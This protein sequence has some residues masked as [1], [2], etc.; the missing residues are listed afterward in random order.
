MP[1]P[2]ALFC[3]IGGVFLTDAWGV[4]AR[5]KAAEAFQL[6]APV[7]E[8]AHAAL[9][10]PLETGRITLDEY[11]DRAV[12]NSPRS[13]TK[14]AFK[15]FMRAQSQPFPEALGILRCLAQ[16]KKYFLACLNN[17]SRELNLHRIR[18][19][20]LREYFSVFLSSCYLGLRKPDEAI[21]RV[22]L[23]I[24]QRAPQESLFI[25]DRE[26]NVEGARRAGM[27][28]IHYQNPAA[29]RRELADYGVII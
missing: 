21:Y 18:S 12:F 7:F 29:L 11:L 13:F 23:E 15:E 3:D 2:T 28:V 27:S 9:L 5:R 1:D 8:A 19:F 22:A 26:I 14:E 20:G 10:D 16:S 4:Q 25:D 24:A 6:D 17:E